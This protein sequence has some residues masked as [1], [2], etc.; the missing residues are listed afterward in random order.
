MKE[1][2]NIDRL[3]QEKFKEFES[4]P[5][6]SVWYHVEHTLQ[7]K[8]V[9]R[10]K[11]IWMWF[12]SGIAVGMAM[13]YILNTPF[14]I[15]TPKNTTDNPTDNP[16]TSSPKKQT[17]IDNTTA[18]LTT[19]L[20][21]NYIN[22]STEIVKKQTIIKTPELVYEPQLITHT[23]PLVPLNTVGPKPEQSF[24]K[25]KKHRLQ[26]SLESIAYENGVTKTPKSNEKKW[27]VTTMAAP[28]LLNA[29]DNNISALDTKMNENNKNT[30][31][32]TSYGVQVAYKMNQKFTVQTGLHVVD[33]AYL[34]Q[35]IELSTGGR[36]VKYNNIEYADDIAVVSP[37]YNTS[38]PE[39]TYT[40]TSLKSNKGDLTQI[41]GYYEIPVEAKYQITNNKTFGLQV[42][43]GFSTLLLNKNEIFIETANYT[44][45]LGTATNLNTL[46]FSGNVGLELDYKLYKNINLNVVPMFKVQTRTL[47]TENAFKPYSLGL[48]S[49]LNFRF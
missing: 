37:Q 21:P 12:T 5:P 14:N 45:K 23:T 3:F 33:Y 46:N 19:N 2:K 16:I 26:E 9:S 1:Q 8:T 22:N 44:N 11:P 17:I 15:F 41:Y 42:I 38:T 13:L 49:G 34:T 25:T 48:Y 36:I 29:F 47:N 32:S 30:Q 35:N 27:M 10:Q 20:S 24:D 4:T 40:E 7:K 18:P 28:V 39:T 6:E 43:G 31:F